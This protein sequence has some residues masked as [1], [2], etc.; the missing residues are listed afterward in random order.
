MLVRHYYVSLLLLLAVGLPACLGFALHLGQDTCCRSHATVDPCCCGHHELPSSDA[1]DILSARNYCHIC[2]FLALAKQPPAIT[3][4][5]RVTFEQFGLAGHHVDP[6]LV[7]ILSAGT[8]PRGP[9]VGIS[10]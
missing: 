5:Y 10:V 3:E 6:L 2:D 1:P 7:S 8:S 4:I 9:P